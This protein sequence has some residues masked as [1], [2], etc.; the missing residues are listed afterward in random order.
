M[1]L[2]SGHELLLNNKISIHLCCRAQRTIEISIF[3]YSNL[4]QE[5]TEAQNC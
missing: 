4:T 2:N 5:G 3:S 1:I